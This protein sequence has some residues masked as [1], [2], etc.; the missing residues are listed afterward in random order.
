MGSKDM[1]VAAHPAQD[2]EVARRDARNW[3]Y[4][5]CTLAL[6]IG[7]A[8]YW[9][10]ATA[11]RA[12]PAMVSMNTYPAFCFHVWIIMWGNVVFLVTLLYRSPLQVRYTV[13]GR[14]EIP[15]VEFELAGV[16]MWSTFTFWSNT[17]S[18]VYFYVALAIGVYQ[19]VEGHA[20]E[21]LSR[22]AGVLWAII[23]PTS[24]LVNVV[25][26]FVVI[27]A[28]RSQGEHD[29]I[30]KLLSWRLQC[31][32]NGFVT[33]TAMEAAIVLPPMRFDDLPVLI[34]YGACYIVFSWLFF[35]R[36]RIFNYFFLDPRF[37]FAP[38][39]LV[40]LACVLSGYFCLC[41]YAIQL[42]SEHVAVK[43]LILA[44]AVL[45]CTI[46]DVGG[47]PP[48]SGDFQRLHDDGKP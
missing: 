38:Q 40:V 21:S 2:D 12:P 9:V 23:F 41:Y 43:V 36:K 19:Q 47:E 33:G 48:S 24:F 13:F 20:P 37:Q 45:T 8:A 1:A 5:F 46:R 31:L 10:S 29:G 16:G 44:A 26:T 30:Q 34:L 27:P 4:C 42:A 3:I 39:A 6:I 22:A 7:L 17:L 25:M 14:P 32:H 11:D 35:L 18:L 28:L 15:E